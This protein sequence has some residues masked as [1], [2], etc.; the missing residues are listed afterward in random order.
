MRLKSLLVIFMLALN[1]SAEQRQVK[2]RAGGGPQQIDTSDWP[3][4]A[5]AASSDAA[6]AGELDRYLGEMVKR[7]LISGTVLVAKNGSPLFFKS[8]GQGNNNDTKYNLGSINK[9]FTTI[10]LLQ[11]RDAGKIDFQKTLR[12]Y[13]PDYP[14][15][16][17]DRITI[18]QILNHRSG[19][20][21]FF[22]PQFAEADKT[23]I[24]TLQD[25]LPFFV[26][27][28][29][30]FEPG[31]RQRYSNAGFIVLGLVIE[32]LSGVSYYDYVRRNVFAPAGMRD[33]DSYAIDEKVPNRA[34]GLAGGPG[35]RR[36]NTGLIAARG[37]SAG[38]GYS[39]AADL[40]RFS[41]WLKK[42]RPKMIPGGW[43]GGAPGTNA[44]LEVGTE[45]TVIVLSNYS[46]PGAEEAGRNIRRLLGQ[47]DED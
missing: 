15:E 21:D 10:A 36:P 2:I 20:G 17:A 47:N 32:K 45:W 14:S 34:A 42:D 4:I 29:L 5:A 1:V 22:G 40:L 27:K 7:D 43:A 25:Y 19:L 12:T 28:P 44:L 33:T 16:V 13:L 3:K 46:P 37:S 41:E 31:S 26:N 39:T 18:A 6:I 23:K 35:E 8:Y 30:E 24:R 38:G 11:L 9:L